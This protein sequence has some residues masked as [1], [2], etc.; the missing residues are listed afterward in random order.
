MKI[1]TT[2]LALLMSLTMMAETT[3]DKVV[4]TASDALMPG[5]N[6]VKVT[7]SLEGSQQYTGYEMDI[8]LPQ[9]IELNKYNGQ[10][11]VSMVKNGGIYPAEEDWD[12]N[13]TYTHTIT[14]TY[15]EVG[16]KT[17]RIACI[18]T[19]N[20]KFTS[21]SGKLLTL[22]L[23]ASLF[24]KPGPVELQLANTKFVV[25]NETTMT[26]T[27]YTPEQKTITGVSVG[28]SATASIA[29]SADTNWGTVM[30]PFG[31]ELPEG[32]KAYSCNSTNANNL[33]LKEESEIKAFTPYILYSESGY[34]GTLTG[35][36]P[37]ASYPQ[38]DIVTSGYL[39]AAVT[40]QTL[41]QGYVMQKHDGQAQFL[42]INSATPIT[43]QPGKCWVELPQAQS[44]KA[45]YGF[46]IENITAIKPLSV[47]SSDNGIYHT[48][49]G[50]ET[51]QLRKGNIYIHNGKKIIR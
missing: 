10:P 43:I 20:Q 31:T 11:K 51:S 23:K 26:A 36:I 22:Y 42:K 15:G 50:I 19:S 28:T 2:I 40:S 9:G 37:A 48:I 17:I 21:T 38:S 16:E 47:Q 33:I 27:G 6:E 5:G 44:S 30:L 34:S 35:T 46:T 4:A 12:G 24:A 13:V 49:S 1:L 3:T 45:S 25:F 39:K 18:S 7:L 41:T 8:V 32:V 29:I 14:T